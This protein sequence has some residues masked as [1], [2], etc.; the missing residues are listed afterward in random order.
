LELFR[1]KYTPSTS[2]FGFS[3]TGKIGVYDQGGFI[4]TFGSSEEEFKDEVI[5]LKKK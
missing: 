1:Y 2:L 3:T 4:H 5:E